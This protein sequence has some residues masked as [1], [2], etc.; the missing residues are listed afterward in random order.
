MKSDRV[1]ALF[2]YIYYIYI[3]IYTLTDKHRV[4]APA[5]GGEGGQ[6]GGGGEGGEGGRGG[7]GGEGGGRMLVL[8]SHRQPKF[9]GEGIKRWGIEESE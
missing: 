8:P 7:G 6:G 1:C 9:I 5:R 2:I 4:T 3:H